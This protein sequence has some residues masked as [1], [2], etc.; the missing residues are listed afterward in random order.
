VLPRP[1]YRTWQERKRRAAAVA[2][3]LAVH[4]RKC[5]NGDVIARCPECRK[6]R[7]HWV[8]DHVVPFAVSGDET[9]E[10]TV[11]CRK[12]SASQGARIANA[13]RGGG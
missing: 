7:A 12:C 8:A 5:A 1:D 13:R 10:L 9:G 3:F 11:H 4:G 2:G 6:M